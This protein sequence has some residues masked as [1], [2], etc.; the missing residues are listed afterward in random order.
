MQIN[1]SWLGIVVRLMLRK[2]PSIHNVYMCI[3]HIYVEAQA[4]ALTG[5]RTSPRNT[6]DA[7][8]GGNPW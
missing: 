4:K 3:T 7:E 1:C 6:G 2:K 5:C 8:P